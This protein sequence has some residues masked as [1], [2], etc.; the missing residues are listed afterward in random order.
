MKKN[1]DAAFI[2]Y[3]EILRDYEDLLCGDFRVSREP[4][5]PINLIVESRSREETG[6]VLEKPSEENPESR[7]RLL[8]ALYGEV[9]SCVKCR[10]SQGRNRAVPGA[11]V[12]DPLVMVIGEGPGAEEDR[13]GL[14]FVGAAGKFLDKWLSA[15]GLSRAGNAY[16]ANI[17]KCR[18]PGNR[19]PGTDEAAA[20]RPYLERQ[21]EIIRPRTILAVGRI[22]AQNLI[23]SSQG[24]GAVRGKRFIF[25][26][27]P[28]TATYHPSA[29]LRDMSLKRPVWEDLK[30]LKEMADE[31][32]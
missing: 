26:G 16:I 28:M 32:A 12:L 27:V 11:G 17:V 7:R 14:P 15:I 19:D 30:T 1:A 10:L 5:A 3:G 2:K 6:A 9:R 13:E 23:G 20:C 24:I 29:V 31:K 18:P 22:A 25:R 8:D 21:I 4:A